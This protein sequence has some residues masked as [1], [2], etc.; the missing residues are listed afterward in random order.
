[1]NKKQPNI[2]KMKAD[3]KPQ[4]KK[5]PWLHWAGTHVEA[6]QNALQRFTLAPVTAFLAILVVGVSLSLPAAFQILVNNLEGGQQSIDKQSRISVYLKMG[7]SDSDVEQLLAKIALEPDVLNTH[8]ISPEQGLADFQVHNRMGQS[9]SLLDDNPLPAM[10][11]VFPDAR[12][13]N[14]DQ[15]ENLSRKLAT[16]DFV[17]SVKIDV[18]WLKRLYAITQFVSQIAVAISLFLIFTVFIVIGN[19][20]KLLGQNFHEEITVSKLVGATDAYVRRPFLYSGLL[21]GGLGSIVA[22]GFVFFGLLWL[23]PQIETLGELYQTQISMTGISFSDALSIIGIGMLLG[24]GGAW[25]AANRLIHR[26]S[27]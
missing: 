21:Y 22:L 14:P 17:D 11:H 9:L 4:P 18:L 5:H 8:Y 2:K 6:L 27:L 25:V 1:M 16:L 19:T 26:L 7:V 13:L 23:S 20:I 12:K 10:I 3:K 24:L 15:I